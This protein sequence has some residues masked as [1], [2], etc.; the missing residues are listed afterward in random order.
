MYNK[1]AKD[2]SLNYL[3]SSNKKDQANHRENALIFYHKALTCEEII[4]KLRS[5]KDESNS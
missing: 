2:H 1:I 3:I 4:E 5:Y